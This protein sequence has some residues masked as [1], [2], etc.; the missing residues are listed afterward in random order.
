[1]KV[2]LIRHYYARRLMEEIC[3]F[4][5][6]GNLDQ[7]WEGVYSQVGF[8]VVKKLLRALDAQNVHFVLRLTAVGP[9][10]ETVE[11]FGVFLC[12]GDSSALGRL[13]FDD[14]GDLGDFAFPGAEWWLP[15]TR[16]VAVCGAF[17]LASS[18][19]LLG[20]CRRTVSE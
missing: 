10:N 14:G 20:G 1:M 6:S 4:P 13:V 5:T 16:G 17:G 3:P 2:L 8:V 11:I 19:C 9:Q 7:E 18:A 12:F 15:V